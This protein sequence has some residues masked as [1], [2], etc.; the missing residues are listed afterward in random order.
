[1][2]LEEETGLPAAALSSPCAP[3]TVLPVTDV[4]SLHIVVK[5]TRERRLSS[6][7]IHGY[8]T[9]QPQWLLVLTATMHISQGAEGLCFSV[10]SQNHRFIMAGNDL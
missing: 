2:G 3:L 4:S 7:H 8:P 9:E 10:P 1:M 6:T 5:K